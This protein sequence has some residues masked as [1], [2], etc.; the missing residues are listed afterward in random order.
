MHSLRRGSKLLNLKSAFLNLKSLK[1]QLKAGSLAQ[2]LS[3]LMTDSGANGWKSSE[4]SLNSTPK[5]DA[6]QAA[7]DRAEWTADITRCR[8]SL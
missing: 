7:V 6:E 5:G 8:P 4:S 2:A 3:L 1:G